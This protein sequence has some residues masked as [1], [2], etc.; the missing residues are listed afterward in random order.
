MA[1]RS[2]TGP[3]GQPGYQWVPEKGDV[4]T[5]CHVYVP[6]DQGSR[7]A[8]LRAAIRDGDLEGDDA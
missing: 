8:A 7:T 3:Q 6:N 5:E 4:V 1:V 2:C